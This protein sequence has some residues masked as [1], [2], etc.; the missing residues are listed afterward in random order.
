MDNESFAVRLNAAQYDL[1]KDC[2]GVERAAR[3][4]GYGESTV[5]R[6]YDRNKPDVMPLMAVV[7]LEADCGKPHVT[8]ILAS[9]TGRRLTDPENPPETGAD[10]LVAHAHVV[11]SQA[12]LGMAVAEAA[13]D[14]Q[15]TPAEAA[16]MDREAAGLDRANDI[17]R[18]KLASIRAKSGEKS[19]L[20]L[21]GGGA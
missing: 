2:A 1:I 18:A 8:E 10:L 7:A 6:W 3:I 17:L 4:C 11:N 15:I 16:A 20:T 9:V 13:S 12:A 5:G 19:G 14:G 21:V